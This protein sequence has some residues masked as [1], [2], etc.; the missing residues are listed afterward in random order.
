[1]I[2]KAIF[3]M[4]GTIFDSER[5]FM[6]C[7]ISEAKKFGYLITEEIYVNTLGLGKSESKK[8]MQSVF[9]EDYPFDEISNS[10]RSAIISLA[11]K[12]LPVKN[13]IC[14]LLTFLCKN[15]VECVIASSTETKY[16]EIYLNHSNLNKYFSQIIGGETVQKSKPE[17]DIFIK[18]LGS[19]PKDK[20]VI[21]EDSENGIIAAHRAGIPVI[22]IPD[23]KQ[24][25]DDVLNFATACVNTAAD[26]IE[27][28]IF[29]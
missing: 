14:E 22:C 15:E 16:I 13:G 17:P 25:C 4:D 8:Y 26:V 20:A 23:M 7:L 18:A 27:M 2:Q 11:H 28:E 10:A 21:F 3:D 24:P 1:M 12:G 29:K 19:V 9:G 6:N 5:L